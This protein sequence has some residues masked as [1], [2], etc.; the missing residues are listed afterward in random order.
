MAAPAAAPPPLVLDAHADT[1]DHVVRAVAHSDFLPQALRLSLASPEHLHDSEL[2]NRT[3]GV[4]GAGGCTLLMRAVTRL[5]VA[6]AAEI[7]AACPAPATRVELLACVDACGLTALHIACHRDRLDEE[8]ALR[9]VELL[10]ANGA[11][12]L[13]L[14]RQT[15]RVWHAIHFAAQW[16]AG[17]VQRLVQAGASIDGDAEHITTLCAAIR[18]GRTAQGVHM[19][20]QLVALGAREMLNG[21]P[22]NWAQEMHCIYDPA[23]GAQPTDGE[24]AASLNALVSVGCSLSQ[25]DDTELA[26]LD[27]AARD[28]NAPMV[29]A[30]LSLGVPAST[31]SLVHGASHPELV[32]V[33]LAAAAPVEGLVDIHDI[34]ERTCSPLMEAAYLSVLESVEALLAAGASV[35]FRDEDCEESGTVLMYSITQAPRSTPVSLRRCWQRARTSTRGTNAA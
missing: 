7:L 6:R 17:L 26:P 28:G 31:S 25:P 16:S 2:L 10:L 3:R 14:T 12:P 33:L 13:E 18:A 4:R 22:E 19:I 24:V 30:L 15:H 8:A 1:L 9:M 23:V 21:A 34:D 11:D 32:R 35:H 29:R 20:P 5:D 27:W